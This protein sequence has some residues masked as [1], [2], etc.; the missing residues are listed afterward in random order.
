MLGRRLGIPVV[1]VQ[2]VHCLAPGDAPTLRLLAAIRANARLGNPINFAVGESDSEESGPENAGEQGTPSHRDPSLAGW[3]TARRDVDPSEVTLPP[4][5]RSGSSDSLPQ[6]AD[7]S[8]ESLHWL[9]P[10]EIATRFVRFPQAVAQAGEIAARCGECLPDGRAIWPAPKLPATQTPDDA[11][12]QLAQTGYLKLEPRNWKLET[13]NLAFAAENPVLEN[14]INNPQSTPSYQAPTPSFRQPA[15]SNQRPASARLA[16]ELC[17]IN[18]HGYAP[19]FL[20]VADIVR[21][22]REHDIPVSTR[23]S[24][25]NS[26]V[27]YCAGI[28]TVDPIERRAAV[29][30]LPQSG[31]RQPTGYRPG[32]LQPTAG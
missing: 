31:T 6:T 3:R 12:A 16:H 32:L 26:L 7:I 14:E 27:A 18:S 22:A 30:A 23:G 9:S 10:A 21:F 4:A 28:T 19:L 5:I 24:V 20:V 1:A 25:A 8:E 15:S 11:L 13:G 29:R 17:E 2:P